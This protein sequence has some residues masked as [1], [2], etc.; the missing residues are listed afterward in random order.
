MLLLFFCPYIFKYAHL[1]YGNLVKFLQAFLLRHTLVDKNN[2]KVLHIAKTN[3]LIDSN[4]VT[5][6]TFKFGGIVAPLFN[7]LTKQGH[8]Q[9]ISIFHI[10]PS[11]LGK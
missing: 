11:I 5:H 3:Q 10:Y 4:M 7:C 2:V 6:A 9:N 1:L 8:I